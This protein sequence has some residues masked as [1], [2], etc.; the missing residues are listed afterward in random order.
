MK[1]VTKSPNPNSVYDLDPEN[2]DHI[3][4][5]LKFE[6]PYNIIKSDVIA[7]Q[8]NEIVIQGVCTKSNVKSI[9][10]PKN[11]NGVSVY[12]PIIWVL[13]IINDRL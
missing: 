13:L 12:P 9:E 6:A 4:Q 5:Y 10:S 8:V 1:M 3:E 11:R 2:D 7:E